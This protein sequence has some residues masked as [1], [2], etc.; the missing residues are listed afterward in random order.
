MAELMKSVQTPFVSLQKGTTVTGVITKLTSSEILV[1]IGSKTDAVVLEKDRN[2]LKNILATLTVGDSVQ[3]SI[4]N[5]ES[6]FGNTVVSIRRFMDE[7]LWGKVSGLEK[8]KKDLEIT[9]T[10]VT[11]GGFVVETPDGIAGFLPNSHVSGNLEI[12]QKTK[13]TLL[14]FDKLEHK[15]IFSQK[16]I[17]G[18]DEFANT[19]KTLKIEQKISSTINNIAPFGI[20]VTVAIGDSTLEGFIHI[21]EISWDKIETVPDTYKIGNTLEA[22]ILGFDKKSSRINL[23]IKRLA[24]DPNIEK[25]KSYPID[26][27]VEGKV[28]KTIST[29]VIIDLPDGVEGFIKKDK[30]PVGTTYNDGATI[31]ATVSDIDGKNHRVILSPYLTKKSIGYR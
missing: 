11:R 8:S 4:L 16:K 10:E 20:F 29:G 1:D 15:I 24:A 28:T 19:T 5:P 18:S 13:A 25:L 27:K 14:E 30:I 9:I 31:T 26:K 7:K 22:Q 17:V 23:S 6:D 2:L 3:V 21:S 12:G